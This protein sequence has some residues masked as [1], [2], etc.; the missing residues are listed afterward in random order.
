MPPEVKKIYNDLSS[1]A[2][3]KQIID[4]LC[5]SLAIADAK[6]TGMLTDVEILAVY[7]NLKITINKTQLN[8]LILPLPCDS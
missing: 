1:Y 4:K 3:R 7:R 8:H 2:K 5:D 6:K